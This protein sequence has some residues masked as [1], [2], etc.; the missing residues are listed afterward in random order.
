MGAQ[1]RT[2]RHHVGHLAPMSVS[3]STVTYGDQPDQFV[4]I[5]KPSS[6]S[7]GTIISIHGG[8]WRAKYGLDLHIPIAEHLA[9]QG[10]TVCNIEYRRV[11]PNSAGI[12]PEM[13][14]DVLDACA[15]AAELGGP[16]VAIG[17]SAGGQLALWAAAQPSTGINAVIALAPVS[18]L[19][20]A[21]GLE[22]SNHA[23]KELL[24][25][26]AADR[27]DLYA[28]A[29]P[30]YLLPLGIPQLLV[31]GKADD[32]VPFEMVPEYV[33]AATGAGD[34]IQLIDPAKVDH[35]HV[36]DPGHKVWR[37]IDDVLGSWL[38]NDALGQH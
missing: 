17:H 27:P 37:Q 33:E 12:W 22:L 23:T 11:H 7:I 10:W 1:R 6:A 24:G 28:T 18:D 4:H 30:L 3:P 2:P 19:F 29:S 20:L 8:Y 13:S 26:S 32:D 16:T 5:Y 35:F 14:S 34:D 38:D 9:K 25:T 21:D 31:H 36:I 15:L